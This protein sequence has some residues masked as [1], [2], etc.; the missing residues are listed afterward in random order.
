MAVYRTSLLS[1]LIVSKRNVNFH[2]QKE[3]GNKGI[4]SKNF[5]KSITTRGKPIARW[6]ATPVETTYLWK[7]FS[8]KYKSYYIN[9]SRRVLLTHQQKIFI[10]HDVYF[11]KNNS[12]NEVRSWLRSAKRIIREA[13]KINFYNSQTTIF[14]QFHSA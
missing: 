5:S 13:T 1:T 8:T 2:Y 4:S 9:R 3:K 12:T 6:F 7:T 10:P 14:D 11:F